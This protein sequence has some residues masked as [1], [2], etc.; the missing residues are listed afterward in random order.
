MREFSMTFPW[1]VVTLLKTVIR[2]NFKLLFKNYTY[3][4]KSHKISA[5]LLGL[6]LCS[7]V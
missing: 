7:C 1:P 6:L 2:Y 3:M 5:G 4:S